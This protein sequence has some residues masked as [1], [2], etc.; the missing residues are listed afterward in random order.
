MSA[1]RRFPPLF[2]RMPAGRD[3]SRRDAGRG[4]GDGA[5]IFDAGIRIIEVPLNSPEPLDSIRI[6]AEALGDRALIG[7]GTVLESSRCGRCSTPA[8]G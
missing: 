3:H 7:A 6:I 8:A 4:G 2:R 1:A 5:A